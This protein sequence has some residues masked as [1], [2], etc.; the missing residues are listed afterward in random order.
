MK[1]FFSCIAFVCL[2]LPAVP[3]NGAVVNAASCGRDDVER[4]AKTLAPND[5]LRL[6][7]GRCVWTQ[8]LITALPDGVVVEGGGSE[9]SVGAELIDGVKKPTGKKAGTDV[10]ILVDNAQSRDFLWQIGLTAA[11]QTVR[12]IAFLQGSGLRKEHGFLNFTGVSKKFRLSRVK[13]DNLGASTPGEMSTRAVRFFGCVYGVADHIIVNGPEQF[14]I[15]SDGCGLR[16]A[17]TYDGDWTWTEDA[18]FGGPDFMFVEDSIFYYQ[19]SNDCYHGGKWVFRYNWMHNSGGVQ[20]HPTTSG[21]GRG[22]RA[23]EAYSNVFMFDPGLPSYMTFNLAFISSGSGVFHHNETLGMGTANGITLHSMR[24]DAST[25]GQVAPP[26]GPGYCTNHMTGT[27]SYADRNPTPDYP[28]TDCWD[29]PGMG[30][31]DLI[32]GFYNA[33]PAKSKT[34]DVT[35]CNIAEPC[36]YPH[37]KIDP[38]YF[39]ENKWINCAGCGGAWIANYNGDLI[40]LGVHYKDNT[41]RP[42]YAPYVYPH[43]LAG[44]T[45][46]IPPDPVPPANAPPTISA[47]QIKNGTT[48][49]DPAV[50][51][52]IKNVTI[53]T[54]ASDDTGVTWLEIKVNGQVLKSLAPTANPTTMSVTWNTAPYKGKGD[55]V[56]EVLARDADGATAIRGISV[57]VRK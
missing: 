13:F 5:V 54:A 23:W 12:D 10:T 49:L 1:K 3:L 8:S 41:P 48:A 36:F 56:I 29:Q 21:S 40:R 4:A 16:P 32:V 24:Y 39:W 30:Q 11:G 53:A 7:G 46:P 2:L 33:D 20:T 14:D 45:P 42:G 51:I 43:P 25:Y 35:K 27:V 34:N 37:Q 57:K 44:G 22:C 26:A 17:E 6:P 18:G 28:F 15:W 50:P 55:V 19:A 31:Q 52:T 38:M 9:Y 47:L